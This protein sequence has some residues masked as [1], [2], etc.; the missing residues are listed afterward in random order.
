MAAAPRAPSTAVGAPAGCRRAAPAA[1]HV[2]KELCEAG[3][4]SGE[5]CV[6]RFTNGVWDRFSPYARDSAACMGPLPPDLV[7]QMLNDAS[8]VE[9]SAWEPITDMSLGL[10]TGG[11][12][13][14]FDAVIGG[15]RVSETFGQKDLIESVDMPLMFTYSVPHMSGRMLLTLNLTSGYA[16]VT[17]P[18]GGP[19]VVRY[20]ITNIA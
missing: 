1:Y 17:F 16:G 7:P 15:V 9:A 13:G 11:H 14:K 20:V 2:T 3:K 19:V 18:H 10:M 12:I 4:P 5:I 6:P 8:L